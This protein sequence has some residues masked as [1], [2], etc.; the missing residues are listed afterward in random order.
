MT[1]PARAKLEGTL[2]AL[3]NYDT[4]FYMDE[5]DARQEVRVEVHLA[6]RAFVKGADMRAKKTKAVEALMEDVLKSYSLTKC[7]G[8]SKRQR[9]LVHFLEEQVDEMYGEIQDLIA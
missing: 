8:E 3:N 2:A 5:P 7:Q 9:E 6:L 1:T 4:E